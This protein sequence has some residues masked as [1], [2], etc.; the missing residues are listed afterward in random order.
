MIGARLIQ[1]YFTETAI[2]H[3]I[4]SFEMADLF[5]QM[6]GFEDISREIDSW[7]ISSESELKIAILR[8]H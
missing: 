1:F 3:L 2:F 8:F 7:V 6:Y 5:D 4:L